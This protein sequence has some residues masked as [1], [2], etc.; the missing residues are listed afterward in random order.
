M[1]MSSGL[2]VAAQKPIYLALYDAQIV[3]KLMFNICLGKNGG[4]FQIGGY[5]EDNHLEEISWLPMSANTGTSY[6]FNIEGIS[7]NN[8]PIRGSHNWD[9]GFLDS[10]TTFSYLPTDMW[11]SLMYHFDYFCDEARK[12]PEIN[13]IQ[14]YCPGKRFVTVSDGETLTCWEFEPEMWGLKRKEFLMGF[15][16]LNF[17]V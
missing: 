4:Y 17:H 10:G 13:G 15:P 14:R 8:H 12:Q 3:P 7:M 16:V 9:V 2:S 5:N 6:K 1:G 11:D